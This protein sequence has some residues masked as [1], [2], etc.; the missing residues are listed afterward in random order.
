MVEPFSHNKAKK[1]SAPARSNPLRPGCHWR[2]TGA[3][4]VSSP[5]AM[6]GVMLPL[7]TLRRAGDPR[8]ATHLPCVDCQPGTR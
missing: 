5:L 1:G 4:R 2:A 8:P 7:R 6:V 3:Q